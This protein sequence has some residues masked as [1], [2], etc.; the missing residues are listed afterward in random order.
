MT[1]FKQLF[2]SVRTTHLC[3]IEGLLFGLCQSWRVKDKKRGGICRL[4]EL[5]SSS[6]R[7]RCV[8]R[9]LLVEASST[10]G[11]GDLEN[12]CRGVELRRRTRGKKDE[13]EG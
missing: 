10:Y 5:R 2:E 7:L 6:S 8:E 13:R 11:H 4:A 3:S 9:L 12:R 1:R